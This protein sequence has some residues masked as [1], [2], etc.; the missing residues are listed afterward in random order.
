M[1]AKKSKQNRQD[2]ILAKT[3]IETPMWSLEGRTLR[4][5]CVKVYDGDTIHVNVLLGDR[6]VRFKCRMLGYDSPEMNAK[7]SNEKTRAIAARDALSGLICDQLVTIECGKFDKYGRL[8]IVCVASDGKNIN[9][10]M[11]NMG[12]GAPYP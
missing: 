5:K 8:L 2:A 10:W 4:A 11:L 9:E 3:N 12:H 6:P 1:G 7:D